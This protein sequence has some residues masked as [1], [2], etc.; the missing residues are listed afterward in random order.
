MASVESIEGELQSD[1]SDKGVAIV[2][3]DALAAEDASQDHDMIEA[4]HLLT[5]G[6]NIAQ[7]GPSD[8][9]TEGSTETDLT[10]QPLYHDGDRYV[11]PIRAM[12]E[13]EDAEV[14]PGN[15]QSNSPIGDAQS[16]SLCEEYML[17]NPL[18]SACIPTPPKTLADD[19]ADPPEV[20]SI[21]LL[22]AP[23]V[24]NGT[25]AYE[26]W[27][28]DRDSAGFLASV[29]ALG[30]GDGS[31][32]QLEDG[33]ISFSDLKLMEPLLHVDPQLDMQQLKRRNRVTISARGI[34]E[35]PLSTGKDKSVEWPP[36]SLDL[37]MQMEGKIASDKMEVSKDVMEYLRA[38]ADPPR[39]SY[40]E[41][42]DILIDSDKVSHL[43]DM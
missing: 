13:P 9:E 23:G 3:R 39:L 42:M 22:A 38:I 5:N 16:I 17:D 4:T 12:I 31:P 7:S 6:F 29:L 20:Q 35:I 36:K 37:L 32:R 25:N 40:T 18:T 34:K 30:R 8:A 2:P 21:A 33:Y 24:L 41:M 15:D 19:L 43:L 14:E 28:V 1:T 10:E 27:D 11:R 26:K